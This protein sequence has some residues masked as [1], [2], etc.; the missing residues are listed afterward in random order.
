MISVRSSSYK[1]RWPSAI[2]IL[3]A[4][5]PNWSVECVCHVQYKGETWFRKIEFLY[6]KLKK[7]TLFVDLPAFHA[8]K[9]QVNDCNLSSNSYAGHRVDIREIAII[10]N[11]QKK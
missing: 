7:N 8:E 6:R 1:I 9:G 4:W 11:V 2:L 5:A 10:W 3:S